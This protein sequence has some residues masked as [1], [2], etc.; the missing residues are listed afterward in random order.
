MMVEYLF[1]SEE[2]QAELKAALDAWIGT[3]FRHQTGVKGFGCDCAYFVAK[4]IEEMGALVWRKNLMPD[5]PRDWHIH[6]T[7]ELLKETIEKEFKCMAISL[8]GF[9]NGDIIL[10]HYGRAA[11]HVGIFFDGYIYRSTEGI[12]VHRVTAEEKSLKKRMRFAYRLVK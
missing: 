2:K 7:R 3:P 1:K 12:G 4:V 10:F 8:S 5:Y 6:N 11:S 9:L